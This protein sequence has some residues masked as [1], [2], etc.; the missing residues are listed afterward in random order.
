MYVYSF[1]FWNAP[2]ELESR[3]IHLEFV[4]CIYVAVDCAVQV[5]RGDGDVSSLIVLDYTAT[6]LS[7]WCMKIDINLSLACFS[8]K[9]DKGRLDT[10]GI[11][12]L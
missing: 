12:F 2:V 5:S 11:A 3:V 9:G 10:S 6:F 1:T 8:T 7:W 4:N